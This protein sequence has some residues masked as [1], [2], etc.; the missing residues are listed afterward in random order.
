[1]G[2]AAI[3]LTSCHYE[4]AMTALMSANNLAL[5]GHEVHLY[6]IFRG[7]RIMKK[8]YRPWFPGLLFPVTWFYER[9]LKTAGAFTYP[10][11]LETARE[12]GVNFHVC[13][14]CVKL[15]LLRESAL[16]EGVKQ[17]GMPEFAGI[18]EESDVQL[19]F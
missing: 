15:G 5:S 9:K 6:G 7:A 3:I 16:L 8:G 4:Q 13:D 14:L 12:L 19:S 1:M 17:T 10:E 11:Q 18:L 2:K